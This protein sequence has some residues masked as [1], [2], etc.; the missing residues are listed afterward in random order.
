MGNMEEPTPH[1]NTLGYI[2]QY[3][4]L[5]NQVRRTLRLNVSHG[6]SHSYDTSKL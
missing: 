6:T 4:P 1:V 2:P 5:H 3:G